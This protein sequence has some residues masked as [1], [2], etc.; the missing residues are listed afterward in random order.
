MASDNAELVPSCN[1]LQFPEKHLSITMI[2]RICPKLILHLQYQK[3]VKSHGK[4]A[5][6]SLTL[7]QSRSLCTSSNPSPER[8][9]FS[10]IQPTGI[11]H[12]GNYLGA[13]REWVQIQ[14]S[15]T[16]NS[17][18]IFSI[19]DLHALT[20]PQESANLRQWRK[21]TLAILLAIGLDPEQCTIFFQSTV[22]ISTFQTTFTTFPFRLT[23]V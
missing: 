2:G 1:P 18:Y 16:K 9:I 13:L 11:P 12:L 22:C 20:I 7:L 3:L 10:G 8:I 19:V 17:R 5:F 4:T 15:P 6:E 14:N 23:F 21:Q